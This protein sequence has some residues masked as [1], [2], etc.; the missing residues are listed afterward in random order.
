MIKL[1]LFTNRNYY[2]LSKTM[3]SPIV[4]DSGS[5]GCYTN[6]LEPRNK[7]ERSYWGK[8]RLALEAGIEISFRLATPDEIG[9]YDKRLSE[10]RPDLLED[11]NIDC[12]GSFPVLKVGELL[13]PG[14]LV[15]KFLTQHQQ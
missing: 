3:L 4:H 14:M 7:W 6:E 8:V 1:I 15:K 11:P 10:I 2:D 9:V 12:S 5:D 13:D